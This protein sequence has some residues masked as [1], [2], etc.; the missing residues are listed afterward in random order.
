MESLVIDDS[1]SDIYDASLACD[2]QENKMETTMVY[3]NN[4][5]KHEQELTELDSENTGSLTAVLKEEIKY[6]IQT[7]RL[8]RGLSELEVEIPK[9]KKERLTP[10][11][12][13]RRHERREKNRLAATK[14][15]NKKRERAQQL[16]KETKKLQSQK[17]ILMQ[18]IQELQEERE[19][20]SYLLQ[21]HLMN[22]TVRRRNARE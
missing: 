21:S 18:Q 5:G 17:D 13:A 12:E 4:H 14:C 22:C 6:T 8:A 19:Q 1:S 10:E 20:L 3:V 15:R 9:P 16:E 7:K 11:E 2:Q